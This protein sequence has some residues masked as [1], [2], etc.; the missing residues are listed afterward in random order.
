MMKIPAFIKTIRFRLTLWYVSFVILLIFALLIGVN[1]VMWQYRSVLPNFDSQNPADFQSWSQ[2]LTQEKSNIINDL[3]RYSIIGVGIVIVAGA[4]GGYFLSGVMLKPV[5]KIA[6]LAGRSSYTNL[7]ERLNYSGPNDEIKRL[8]DTFDNMLT[9]L[10]GAVE[11]QKQF[12]QDASHELRTPIATALTNIEVLEMNSE[13]TIEDYQNLSRILKLSLDRINNISNSLLLLSEEANATAKWSKVDIAAVMAEVVNESE[14]EAMRTGIN[15]IRNFSD[16]EAAILGDAFRIKQAVFNLVD[17]ALKYNIPGGT[18]SVT[19]R[20]EGEFVTIEVSDTGI[21]IAEED[22]PRIF[23]RFFR[24]DKSRS[25]QRGGSGLG[26]AIVKTI[27]EE[28][29]GHVSVNSIP[30][31]GST[32]CVSLPLYRLS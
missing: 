2:V 28:H 26:L 7:K 9:R 30:G 11:S 10:E 16:S 29:R 14:V 12:I 32:F 13:A 18:V 17:N 24:V 19:A 4:I 27:V 6:L 21:G 25:R 5:D 20:I 1:V 15:L 3:R 22:L 31:R 8:A 23:D